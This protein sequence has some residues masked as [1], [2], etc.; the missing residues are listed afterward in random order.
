M[1]KLMRLKP[2]FA[3]SAPMIVKDYR[4]IEV[5]SS[6][7]V[8]EFPMHKWAILSEIDYAEVLVPIDAMRKRVLLVAFAVSVLLGAVSLVIAR[9]LSKPIQKICALIEQVSVGDLSS[10]S[11]PSSSIAEINAIAAS[12]SRLIDAL[13]RTR[14]FATEIGS[15][16]FE[17]TFTPLSAQ[18]ETGRSLLKMQSQLKRLMA[19]AEKE[20]ALRTAS[21]LEGEESERNRISR[22]LHDGLGQIL[23]AIKFQAQSLPPSEKRAELLDL[24]D[25]AIEEVRL[26]SYN[27]MPRVLMDFGLNAALQKLVSQTAKRAD[28]TIH[29][30][31]TLDTERRFDEQLEIGIFRIAQEAMNNT[32][33]HAEASAIHMSLAERE[34]KLYFT[35]SDNGRGF[36]FNSLAHQNGL[37]NMHER[38]KL[39]GGTCTIE[40]HQNEGTRIEVALPIL[41]RTS[42]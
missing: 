29:F 17:A 13:H 38:A 27:L 14:L 11:I 21:L 15:G 9:T 7:S 25:D 4:G 23:T 6:F 20:S 26:L 39:L 10:R 34:N 16:N 22:E 2:L 33:K 3:G 12:V 37:R 5:L 30:D 41:D 40:T 31:N 35:F 24:L 18:D 1:P 42:S 8:L 36:A 19:L 32:L 28:I